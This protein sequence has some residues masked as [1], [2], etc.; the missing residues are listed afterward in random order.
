MVGT[1]ARRAIV[2]ATIGQRR[3]VE[4]LDH[5]PVARL[6]GEMVATGRRALR[7]LAVDAGDEQLVGPEPG[8][9]AAAL[10]GTISC[11]S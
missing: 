6:E 7:G 11:R 9:A 2:A 1:L 10:S 3:G 5:R 8:I 4:R